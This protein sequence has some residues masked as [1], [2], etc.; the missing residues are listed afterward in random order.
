MPTT[1]VSGADGVLVGAGIL[2]AAEVALHLLRA[3]LVN[4]VEVA[5]KV[6][7]RG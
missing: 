2:A 4:V 1:A 7:V 3:A 6:A 5:G